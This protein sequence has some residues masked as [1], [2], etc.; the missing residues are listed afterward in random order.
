MKKQHAV[1]GVILLI[2]LAGLSTGYAEAMSKDDKNNAKLW[3]NYITE[4]I[5]LTIPAQS[6]IDLDIKHSYGNITVRKGKSNNIIIKGEKRVSFKDDRIRD[7][8]MKEL[9]LDI[10]K[11]ANRVSITTIY[12][13]KKYERKIKNV[14]ISYSIEVPENVT[15]NIN[16]SFGDLDVEGLSGRFRITNG[17]GKLKA[18]KLDGPVS[19]KNKFS[20]IHADSISGDAEITVE[21]GEL[22]INNIDGNL[23]SGGSFGAVKITAVKGDVTV[24]SQHGSQ[25]LRNIGGKAT[26]T[27]T[28]GSVS[29]DGVG[30]TTN[31]H[32][33]HC[34]VIVYNIDSKATITNSFSEVDVRNV[35]GDVFVK[36]QHG[37]VKASDISGQAE[38]HTSFSSMNIENV[39]GNVTATNQHGEITARNILTAFSNEERQIKMNSSFG[40]INVWFP[41]TLSS[42]L[43][44]S[45]SF[46]KLNCTFPL[47]MNLANVSDKKISGTIGNGND[48][49]ELETSHGD[50]IINKL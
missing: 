25:S 2:L 35:K 45:T 44:A 16:N 47:T 20:P 36:N 24:R 31:V 43:V 21:H 11:N 10:E 1:F 18:R 22:I 32:N 13:G 50:I 3:G 12:P 30:G 14:S 27:N 46:G 28:H 7:E 49:I 41:E 33:G 6:G 37:R 17:F 19:L 34:K 23:I 4:P 40:K 26:V 5:N 9:R 48:Y 15:L 29:I 42:R 8:Y 38:I 39:G